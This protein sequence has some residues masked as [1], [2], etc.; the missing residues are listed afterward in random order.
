MSYFDFIHAS[1]FYELAAL[2]AFTSFIGLLGQLFRQP[3]IV[4]Y[5][6]VGILAGPSALGIVRSYENIEQ[7][8]ELSV[9]VL[10][11]L[12]GMKLDLNKVK[13]LGWVSL[14]TGLG[15]VFFTSVIGFFIVLAFHFDI[16]SALYISIALTFSSTI[17]IVKLLSDKR[18]VDSLHGR[19]A[20]GFLIV[21]DLIVVL[22]MM[23]LS[24]FGGKYTDPK[25][26]LTIDRVVLLVLLL[27]GVIGSLLFFIRYI[28]T[29]LIDRIMKSP[30]LM[31]TFCISW[32]AIF[33]AISSYLGFS[34]ELGGLLA[35]IAL[36]SSPFRNSIVSSLASLR[37]FL[38]LFFFISLGFHMDISQIGAQA[39]PAIVLS[40]F[41]LVGNP[42]IVMVIIGFMGYRKRTGFLAGLTVAQ[43]SEFSL[44]FISMGLSIGHISEESLGLVTLVG[45]ITIASSIYMILYSHVIY[46]WIEPYLGVFERKVPFKEEAYDKYDSVNKIYD[47]ILFGLGRYGTAIGLHLK[48]EGMRVLG[49]DYDPDAL[50]RWRKL[51]FDSV[52]GDASDYDLISSLPLQH[53]KW[54]ISTVPHH[55]YEIIYQDAIH[56]LFESLK[57]EKYQGKIA[58]AAQHSE[59]VQMLKEMGA[60]LVFLP[61]YDAAKRAVERLL[62]REIE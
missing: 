14:G 43:I 10:L 9:A 47:I 27:L 44:I 21:Q 36:A 12:V 1:P 59:Q 24:F 60:D 8:A 7:L 41:V 34:K 3:M 23:A 45:L 56:T 28:S 25:I 57:R 4:S 19:I 20:I 11:F 33:A 42:L 15:Q 35:G 22:A 26:A 31:I 54:I 49:I 6:A 51:D 40:I 37:D 58:I 61:Y 29:P 16:I 53:A 2:L 18:E 39:W 46:D 55:G 32:A 17:I 13:T 50:R 38:L 52:Y 48:P 5:I 30:E 62:N